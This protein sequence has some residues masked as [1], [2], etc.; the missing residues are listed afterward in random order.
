MLDLNDLKHALLTVV[1]RYRSEVKATA[2]EREKADS[3]AKIFF[4]DDLTPL[5]LILKGIVNE[6]TEDAPTHVNLL[7]CLLRSM[8]SLHAITNPM[9]DV[10]DQAFSEL[11]DL[12][13]GIRQLQTHSSSSTITLI[14]GGQEFVCYGHAA[15]YGAS[16]SRLGKLL[17]EEILARLG[18]DASSSNDKIIE[19]LT[20]LK[21]AHQEKLELQQ[22]RARVVLWERVTTS[23]RS[24]AFGGLFSLF[25][26][27]P[28]GKPVS[29]QQ[30]ACEEVGAKNSLPD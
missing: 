7:N 24:V 20:G 6:I 4:K 12:V 14:Q 23:P 16:G 18:L 3:Q 2:L 21:I 17:H 8:V 9:S 5:E 19:K 26:P 10:N 27:L 29:Q 11:C 13:K 1:L 25:P 30:G 15:R 28:Q 22:L